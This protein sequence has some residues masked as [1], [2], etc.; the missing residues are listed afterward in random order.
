[1][2]VIFELYEIRELGR[3]SN[4]TISIPPR[5]HL[6]KSMRRGLSRQCRKLEKFEY[7]YAETQPGYTEKL[8]P[9]NY[10]AYRQGWFLKKRFFKKPYAYIVCTT[11][12]E[13]ENFFKKYINYKDKN[14]TRGKECVDTFRSKWK[15]GMI[16]ICRW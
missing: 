1:M 2:S 8:I 13:M 15:D 12:S 14:D 11:K 9:V 16:F 10:I 5:K 7:F 3:G 6:P 4:L